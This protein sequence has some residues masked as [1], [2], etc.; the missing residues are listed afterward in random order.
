MK[1]KT[2]VKSHAHTFAYYGLDK[3]KNFLQAP[4][5]TCG[6][7]HYANLIL[8]NDDD[9]CSFMHTMLEEWDCSH[10]AIFTVKNGNEVLMGVKLEDDIKCY[11]CVAE[12]HRDLFKDIQNDFEFHCYGIL[13]QVDANSYRIVMD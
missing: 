9:V 13:E 8:K 2:N 12:C 7:G 6:C 10:C 4:I 5:C 1:K 11:K 3:R